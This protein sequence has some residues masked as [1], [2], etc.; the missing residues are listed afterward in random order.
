MTDSDKKIAIGKNTS[1]HTSSS[2]TK[3]SPI[4]GHPPAACTGRITKLRK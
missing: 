1:S 2:I 3:N 4:F